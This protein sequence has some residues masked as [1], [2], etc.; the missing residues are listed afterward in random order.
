MNFALFGLLTKRCYGQLTNQLDQ[1]IPELDFRN[2]GQTLVN[3]VSDPKV[4]PNTFD[5]T[6]ES[7]GS[8]ITSAEDLHK[9][10]EVLS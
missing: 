9:L 1:L 7:T 5:D 8:T 3:I 6:V 10:A 4:L 2:F